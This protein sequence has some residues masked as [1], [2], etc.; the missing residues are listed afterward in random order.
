MQCKALK[1]LSSASR[2]Q[3]YSHLGAENQSN[4]RLLFSIFRKLLHRL[5]ETKYLKHDTPASLAN[6]FIFFFGDKIRK[7]RHDIY[8]VAQKDSS[9]GHCTTDCLINMFSAVSSSELLNIITSTSF[10][11][12]ELDPVPGHVLK[13]LL[14]L[15]Y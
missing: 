15:F 3:Y 13:C 8:R 5:S 2:R 4:L 7:I 11:S 6:D 14:T 10:K 12:C 9:A 1:T